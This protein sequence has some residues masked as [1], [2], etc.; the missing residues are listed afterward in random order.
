MLGMTSKPPSQ[1]VWGQAVPDSIPA[2]GASVH[3]SHLVDT[4]EV[5]FG[6]LVN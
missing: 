1:G 3:P 2:S 6:Q 5:L 4:W